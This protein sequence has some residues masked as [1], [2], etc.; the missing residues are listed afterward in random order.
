MVHEPLPNWLEQV[1]AV[2]RV[3]MRPKVY[4]KT[5][6]DLLNVQVNPGTHHAGRALGLLLSDSNGCL[7]RKCTT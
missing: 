3:D 1:F 5:A 7:P 4:V 2:F 6:E